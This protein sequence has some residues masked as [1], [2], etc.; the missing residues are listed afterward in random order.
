MRI[1]MTINPMI[2][3]GDAALSSYSGFQLI[4]PTNNYNLF[5]ATQYSSV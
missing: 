2:G 3:V 5:G 1:V 4:S